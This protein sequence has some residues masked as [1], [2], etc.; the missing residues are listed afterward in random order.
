MDLPGLRDGCLWWTDRPSRRGAAAC[1]SLA[2]LGLGLWA[3]WA[4]RGGQLELA[5]LGLLPLG[6]VLVPLLLAGLART[7][8][9]WSPGLGRLRSRQ[10]LGPWTLRRQERVV[11]APAALVLRSL[12][13]GAGPVFVVALRGGT[14]GDLVVCRSQAEARAWA[15]AA[16]ELLGLPPP[17]P[18][19]NSEPRNP[20]PRNPEP[21]NTETMDHGE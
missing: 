9:D 10:M 16:S 11:Q 21:R 2:A 3:A 20:E 19:P 17:E 13:L 4:R 12:D 18:L 7:E 14:D 6:L 1:L 15:E 5:L 8:H